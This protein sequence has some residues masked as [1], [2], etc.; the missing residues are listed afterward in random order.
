[1][2]PKTFL[3]LLYVAK[4][5]FAEPSYTLD[6]TALLKF[7]HY[8]LSARGPFLISPLAPRGKIC[9]LGRML[10][11]SFT[12]R[13]EHSL[14]FRWNGGANR[15]FHPQGITSPPGDNFTPRGQNS[16]L[17]S[18]FAPKGEVKN[19]PQ[20]QYSENFSTLHT[21]YLVSSVWPAVLD[22]KTIIKHGYLLQ[23]PMI[24]IHFKTALHVLVCT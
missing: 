2:S 22:W 23:I 24:F 17:G 14:L 13:C 5:S 20:G 6:I 10:T 15:E 7:L 21:T 4:K 16:P 8:T 9:P 1:M 12:P 18:K 19:G 3:S 11:P